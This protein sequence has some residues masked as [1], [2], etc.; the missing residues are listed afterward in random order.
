LSAPPFDEPHEPHDG[1]ARAPIRLLPAAARS[2]LL[3]AL[4]IAFAGAVAGA[5]RVLPWLLDPAVPWRVAAPFARSLLAVA[6]ESAL[7]VGWPV[8]WSLACFRWVETGEARVLQTLGEPPLATTRR[9]VPQGAALASVLAAIALVYGRDA[10]APGRV[11]TELI[12]E[13]RVACANAPS[14]ATYAVPFTDLTWLCA[15][16]AAHREPRLVGTPPGALSTVLLS[17]R[18][19]RIA[20][21]FRSLEVDDAHVLFPGAQPVGLHVGAL[22]MRGMAP[23]GQASTVPPLLRAVVLAVTAWAA[24]FAAAHASLRGA[25]R[26]RA[27]AFVFGAVGPAFAL[28]L[29]R[30]FARASAP[31]V[32][33]ALVPLAAVGC[34]LVAA[35]A[36]TRLRRLR[37]RN[38]AASTRK[39]KLAAGDGM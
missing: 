6:V 12:A 36:N 30:L 21:D 28:A 4:A 10:S 3:A 17:A 33:Y 31:L 27:S 5:V 22:T 2:A 32:A 14:A 13:G 8:G 1:P 34:T 25:A 24:A 38:S 9:L 29:M 7:L 11:A 35:A 18:G 15:P 19:A 39:G 20:G 16:P 26:S 37:D 23:W